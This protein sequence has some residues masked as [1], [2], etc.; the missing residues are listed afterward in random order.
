MIP[1]D[2]IQM[3]AERLETNTRR[4]RIATAA[5]FILLLVIE[6]WQVW[7]DEEVLERAG[8]LLTIAALVYIGYRFRKYRLAS[9]PAALGRTNGAEF[10]RA[11]LLR[12]RDLS[13]DSWGYLLPFVPGVSLALFGGGLA[14]RPAS[15]T[16]ALVAFGVAL[17][18]GIA[19]WNAQTARQLQKEIEALDAS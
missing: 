5:L 7:R 1:L 12:Q 6:A 10:Y 17:F 4:W 3:K 18:A 2:E 8:D 11:E 13:K 15:Q 16:I 19:W 9:Q 14:D